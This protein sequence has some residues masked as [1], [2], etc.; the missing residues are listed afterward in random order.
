MS[1][2]AVVAIKPEMH[3]DLRPYTASDL[4]AIAAMDALCFEPLFRF[5]KGAMRRFAEA[6]NAIVRLAV[7]SARET[8]AERLAG[9]CIVHL[10]R[11]EGN[12]VV[13]YIVTLDVAPSHR[14]QGVGHAL[15]RALET[16]AAEAGAGSMRLHVSVHN[17]PAIRLYERLGYSPVRVEEGF[18]A[19]GGDALIYERRLS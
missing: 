3:I 16:H 12:L 1:G 19:E 4:D 5:S 7:L 2:G 15:M 18:Y 11:P 17:A 9:F 13:G 6:K 10:E 14:G 8:S